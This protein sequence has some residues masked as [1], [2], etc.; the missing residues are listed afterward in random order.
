LNS[1]CPT[2]NRR[3]ESFTSNQPLVYSTV[4]AGQGALLIFAR[5]ADNSGSPKMADQP[6]GLEENEM[7]NVVASVASLCI[8]L[9]ASAHAGEQMLGDQIEALISGNTTYGEHAWKDQH[10]YA[11]RRSDGTYVSQNYPGGR[12]TGTWIIK[13][14]IYCEKRRDVYCHE[15]H[16]MGDGTYR[17][18][19]VKTR[20]HVATWSKVVP[21]NVENLE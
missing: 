8:G 21:G 12:I 5:I 14:D 2:G 18:L 11:Y 19:A 16:D 1:E 9:C 7:R 4:P 20:K 13:G 10:G 3:I 6:R 17:N 15:I